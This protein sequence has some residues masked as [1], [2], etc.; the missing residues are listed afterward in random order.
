MWFGSWL[1]LRVFLRVVL[2]GVDWGG[3]KHA[4]RFIKA[5][6]GPIR[7]KKQA[8]VRCLKRDV[9]GLIAAG[10][11]A[12]AFGRVPSLS[13]LYSIS[14]SRKCQRRSNSFS[15]SLLFSVIWFGFSLLSCPF[16]LEVSLEDHVMIV[17]LGLHKSSREKKGLLCYLLRGLLSFPLLCSWWVLENI[18]PILWLLECTHIY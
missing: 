8:V 5:R 11:E 16:I 18:M 15:T 9:A 4:V 7:N 6:M 3:S 1:F 10:H 12:I 13:R 14:R 2:M 17:L